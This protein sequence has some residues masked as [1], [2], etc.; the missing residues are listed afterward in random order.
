VTVVEV[1]FKGAA[2]V[3]RVVRRGSGEGRRRPD[4]GS[5][6]GV[7]LPRQGLV[8]LCVPVLPAR[9][10][11]GLA[12]GDPGVVFRAVRQAALI[13]PELGRPERDWILALGVPTAAADGLARHR[14]GIAAASRWAQSAF[15]RGAFVGPALVRLFAADSPGVVGT[16]RL[17]IRRRSRSDE[18]EKRSTRHRCLTDA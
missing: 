6:L 4:R 11:T 17:P 9:V 1:Q 3:Q 2:H 18:M 5:A 7:L 15:R 13:A 14:I 16:R 12:C 10:F 8:V